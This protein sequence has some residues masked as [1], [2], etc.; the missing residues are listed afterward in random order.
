MVKFEQIV[1]NMLTNIPAYAVYSAMYFQDYTPE[2]AVDEKPVV[3]SFIRKD[4]V[5]EDEDWVLL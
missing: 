2:P 1:A 4:F 3:W 5:K